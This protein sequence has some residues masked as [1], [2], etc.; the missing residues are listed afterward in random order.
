M[1]REH[2]LVNNQNTE[3]VFQIFSPVGGQL[4]IPRAISLSLIRHLVRLTSFLWFGCIRI[5]CSLL[6][7]T[8]QVSSSILQV[9][10]PKKYPDW[11]SL[12]KYLPA[13]F[14][15]CD[16]LNEIH[17]QE[18]ILQPIHTLCKHFL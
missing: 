14:V 9:Y 1:Y 11:V 5:M 2:Q 17:I 12:R 18:L 7:L 15:L 16:R 10:L 8:Q 6:N 13:L 4:P 3:T